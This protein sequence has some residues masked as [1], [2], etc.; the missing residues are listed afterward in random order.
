MNVAP[1]NSI[2]YIDDEWFYYRITHSEVGYLP[3]ASDSYQ[4]LLAYS[5]GTC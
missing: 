2:P 4:K 1:P 3:Q 5:Y